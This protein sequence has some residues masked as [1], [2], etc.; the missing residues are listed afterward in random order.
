M[1]D[2]DEARI[3]QR[4]NQLAAVTP[5]AE[6]TSAA[7]ARVRQKLTETNKQPTA[8]PT[9]VWRI[10]M[11]SNLTKLAAV[12][13]IVVVA[14]MLATRGNSLRIAAPAFGVEDIGNAMKQAERLHFIL[15]LE[16]SNLDA[17][18]A[19]G[20]GWESWQS[21]NPPR[22]IEKHVDG[23][24]YCTEKDTG[25]KWTYD[26]AGNVITVVQGTP[27]DP[28]EL[29]LTL[30]EQVTEDLKKLE[31]QGAKVE[32]RQGDRQGRP[33]TIIHVDFTPPEGGLHSIFSITVD[34]KTHLIQELTWQQEDTAKGLK[35]VTSGTVDYPASVPTDIY[36]AGAPRD[37]KVVFL[38]QVR[39]TDIIDGQGK[40][41]ADAIT[42][43]TDA[44]RD[45][46]PKRWILTLVTTSDSNRVS[47][48]S[49]DYVDGLKERWEDLGIAENK[50]HTDGVPVSAGMAA[51]RRWAHD[52]PLLPLSI[53]LEWLSDGSYRYYA[54]YLSLEKRWL[55][56]EKEKINLKYPHSG[57]WNLESLGWPIR[58]GEVIEDANAAQR[59]FVR[60][61][62]RD[63]ARVRDGKLVDPATRRVY[64][65]DPNR[66]YICVR[67][68]TYAQVMPYGKPQPRLEELDFEPAAIPDTPTWSR[69]IIEFGRLANGLWYPAKLRQVTA[70][71]A[72]AGGKEEL[73]RGSQI[74]TVYFEPDPVFPPGVFDPN[75]F[76]EWKP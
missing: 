4:L 63:Q 32:Y 29:S 35:G 76:P 16:Q 14:A 58:G 56:Q 37:A 73:R 25:K 5:S 1:Q 28:R 59:G 74:M 44:A 72:P 23:K 60:I 43:L 18:T 6:A 40:A 65:M 48:I 50:V 45:R 11:R 36:E 49:M 67:Q 9:S 41:K 66:D 31:K 26:P 19:K 61:E 7:L 47:H 62:T 15:K 46:L 8:R 68:E 21:L 51:V 53:R 52:L 70:Y 64:F 42:K 69:E 57:A 55:I 75:Q 20:I 34:S 39:G 54:Q 27:A 24:I 71:R 22:S 33:V 12:A 10:V 13:A 30:F 38:G 2:N 17:K 3:R